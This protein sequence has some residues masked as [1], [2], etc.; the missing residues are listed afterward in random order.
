MIPPEL[1][2]QQKSAAEAPSA[3][4][5]IVAGVGTGKTRTLTNRLLYLIERGTPQ[6]K[7]CAI[8]FTNK[9]AKEMKNR[10]EKAWLNSENSKPPFIGTFHFLGAKILRAE[11]RRL[12]RKANFVIF[13]DHDS[14]DLVK[15]I[16]R[17]I[18]PPKKKGE[19]APAKFKKD[20]EKPVFFARKISEI[21]STSFDFENLEKFKDP[22]D[23]LILKIFNLYE[24]TLAENNAFDFDDLIEKPVYLLGQ[25][26]EV[27]EIYQKKFDALLVDEY[28]DINPKQYELI[29]LLSGQHQNLSVVGD[30]EQMIYG[31]RYA[32][33]ETFFGFEKDWRNAQIAFL[34]ENYRSS[35]NI[36]RAAASVA[37]NNKYRRP[38]NLWTKNEAGAPLALFEAADEIEE[39]E[40]IATKIEKLEMKNEKSWVNEKSIIHNSKFIIPSTAVLYRTNAQSRAIE[41]ALIRHQIPYQIFGG[42]RFYERKEVKDIVAALRYVMNK[43]DS[44]SRERLEKTFSKSR[45]ADL[46]A[47]LS[48]HAKKTPAKLIGVFLETADYLEYLERNFANSAE[49]QENVAELVSFASHFEK[50]QPF[51]EEISL[52]QATDIAANARITTEKPAQAAADVP[53]QNL[54]TLMT[55]HMSKGLEFDDVFIAGCSE[56]LLPHAMSQNNEY[57]LEEERR[58]MYVAMTRAKK[59][60]HLSFCEIPS[61]FISEIPEELMELKNSAQGEDFLP[62]DYREKYISFDE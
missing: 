14:F 4:L 31:W 44:L 60:L 5:L 24:K 62:S 41:Q 48:S 46:A 50:L 57:Q 36:I 26:P 30:D 37:S 19:V 3:P 15:K 49:R 27:R 7:I 56:G 8:T 10:V 53:P 43:S 2:P 39:A 12:G 34:E 38:K 18:F 51:L 23:I 61:R 59:E 55:I 58:L 16:C 29:K 54:V 22:K 20:A 33:L 42:L 6:H 47:D 11:A 45:F 35:S 17:K 9:A 28:Q 13:D 25:Y 1:N 32:D 21:K 52:V 40:W